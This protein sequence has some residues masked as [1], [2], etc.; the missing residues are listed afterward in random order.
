MS[1]T[2]AQRFLEQAAVKS[3]DLVHREIIRRGMESYDAAHLKGRARIKDWEAAREKC[4][5]IKREAINHLDRYLVQFEQ[6]VI[7]RGGHVFWAANGHEACSYVKDLATRRGVRTVV[8]SKSM[9]TE[10]IH[11]GPVL[12]EAG[13]KVWE[14]DFGEFIVQLRNE[15]PYHIVTPCMHL[16]RRQIAELFREK[17]QTEIE[18]DDPG[19]LMTV[20]RRKLREAFFSAEMGISGANFLVADVGAIAISTNEG[21]G[22][23]C[24][25][26]PRIHVVVT[27]IEKIIPRLEDLAVLWPVLATS[28]TG[29]GITTYS[30]LIGGP[31]QPGEADGPEEF[32]VVLV[33]NG[34]SRLLADPEQREVLHCIR[35]GACLNICPVF[36][37][38]GGH[39]YGTT[40]PGPIGSVLT[41]HLGGIAQFKHLSYASSL[42]GA[43]SSVCPVKI[44]LHHHLLQNRRNATSAGATK[45]S[46]RLS[47]R[48]WRFAMVHPAIYAFG[49][50]TMRKV[51]RAM[52]GLGLAGSIAD[53]MRPW[54]RHRTPVPL[55]SESFRARWRKELGAN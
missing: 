29:Q 4:Q 42:C 41:P 21:N 2:A 6:Q 11:L 50:W 5:E 23:L 28:G 25:S 47:F 36:R 22:R 7:A 52:Y 12:E 38:I 44:D 27:G 8:K 18:S 19:Y 51:L 14:T 46:E 48:A 39:T 53:P 45:M 17:L 40:Y 54:N 3:A 9:V 10:E 33:D 49:G 31:R 16:N 35:C 24:T 34:R 32:H 30:T 43:C 13:I 1:A 37:H 15:P 26:L 55:P 20:A